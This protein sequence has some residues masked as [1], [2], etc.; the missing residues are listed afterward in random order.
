MQRNCSMASCRSFATH[1]VSSRTLVLSYWVCRL[2][3]ADFVQ[4]TGLVQDSLCDVGTLLISGLV[5]VDSEAWR[6]SAQSA[7]EV[8]R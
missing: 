3:I 2:H 5:T 8:F 4:V 1:V 6:T 7:Y